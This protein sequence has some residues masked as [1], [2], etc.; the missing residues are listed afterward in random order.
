MQKTQAMRLLEGKGVDY[1]AFTYPSSERDAVVVARHLGVPPRQVFKTLV[2]TRDRGKPFL[3]VIPADRQL[4]L[5]KMA[6]T[7]GEKKLQMAS[8]A[9]AEAMT[10]LK[11]GGISPL[12]LL[13]RGFVTILDSSAREFR[14]IFVSAGEKGINLRVP[15]DALLEITGAPLLEIAGDLVA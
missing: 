11:V 4:D 3:A 10:R 14:S 5:K 6:K 13:N 15:V 2:V 7:V 1:E 12:A 9:E 8:H